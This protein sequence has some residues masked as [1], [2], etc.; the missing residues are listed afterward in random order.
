MVIFRD[1]SSKLNFE[2][3]SKEYNYSH[4]DKTISY[5]FDPAVEAALKFN[6]YYKKNTQDYIALN[7]RAFPKEYSKNDE[8]NKINHMLI[9]FVKNLS[10]KF[11][12]DIKMIPM[13]YFHIGEDDREFLNNIKL[14]LQSTNLFVQNKPLTLV[15]TM[16]MFQDA[17]CCIGMRFHSIVLQT[18]LNGSNYI[19]DYT[20]PNKG[21]IHGFIQDIDSNDFYKN[22]YLLLQDLSQDLDFHYNDQNFIIDEKRL[23][24]LNIYTKEL[25][26]I[27]EKL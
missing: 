10:S 11:D 2:E 15:E 25:E 13:H 19:L 5:S 7:L 4:D 14:S 8:S 22:R 27:K 16:K 17:K 1:H 3:I 24:S 12:T 26:K 6:E 18:I 23:D 21:K 20:E 9:D